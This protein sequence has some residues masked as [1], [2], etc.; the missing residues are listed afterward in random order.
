M[1]NRMRFCRLHR[2]ALAA[3]AFL[4]VAAPASA[5][6]VM[7]GKMPASF[8]EGLLSGLGHPIIGPDH[9]AF[10]VAVGIA[11][12]AGGLSLALPLVFIA[13]MTAGVAVHVAGIGLPAAELMVA[14]SVLLAGFLLVRGRPL[15]L[16]VWSVLFAVAGFFHGYTF[17]ESIFGAE[18]SPLAAYLL[19]LTAI[20]AALTVAVA[21]VARRL[22][23]ELRGMTPRLAGAAILGVG[24]AALVGHLVPGV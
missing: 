19:G 13:A 9:L 7:G 2:S 1:E 15:P 20:Q 10:L 3:A 16:A 5:H 6:H 21:L 22:G 23:A 8:A 11:V 17:G 4:L 18:A 12:G 24:F 14:L